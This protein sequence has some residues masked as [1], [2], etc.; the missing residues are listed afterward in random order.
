MERRRKVPFQGKQVEGVEI[1]IR[2]SGEFW[3]E[4]F[5]EDGTVIKVKVVTTDIVRIDEQFDADGNPIY[6]MRNTTVSSVSAPENLRKKV[7]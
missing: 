4:Y 6:V 5:L 3:N 1:P 2:S 7:E